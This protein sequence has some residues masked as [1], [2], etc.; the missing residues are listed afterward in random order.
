MSGAS[1]PGRPAR[2]MWRR[3]ML[4]CVAASMGPLVSPAWPQNANPATVLERGEAIYAR[5]CL[6]CHMRDGRGVPGMAPALLESAWIAGS[7]EALIGF[8]LTGGF[9]PEALMGRFDYI[10]DVDMA[11]L[12]SYLRT[13]FG[14]EQGIVTPDVAAAARARFLPEV[15]AEAK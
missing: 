1:R 2:R 8:V 4:L 5:E 14:A 3:A 6:T 7:P 11:A 9:G 15:A 13:R 10:D 12:M